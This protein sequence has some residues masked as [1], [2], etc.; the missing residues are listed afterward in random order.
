MNRQ[1]AREYI[2]Q[3][4]AEFFERD[5]SGSGFICPICG[6]GS[7]AKGTGITTKDGTHFTCWAGCFTS[8]DI[9]QIIGMQYGLAGFN[10]QLEKAA[11]ELGITIDRFGYNVADDF[12]DESQRAHTN[13]YTHTHTHKQPE[14]AEPEE[15]YTEFF[16]QAH[17]NLDKTNYH[18]GLPRDVLDRFGVG[19]VE[20]WKV[21]EKEYLKK[22]TTKDGR[23]R[24]HETWAAL[25]VSPRLI[26][27]TSPNSYLA[28]DTRPN[29]T[30]AEY[31]YRAPKVGK[32][33]ILN[34]D[35]IQ[36]ATSPIFIVEGEIDTL[37][38]IA[39]GGAAVGLGS[40]SMRGRLQRE[41]AKNRPQQ[42]L[43]IALDNDAAGERA[44]E[45]LEAFC[46]EQGISYY[47]AKDLYGSSKD[48]NEAWN[49]HREDFMKAVQDAE[50]AARSAATAAQEEAEA[51]KAAKLIADMEEIQGES[52]ANNID[53]LHD[54][55]RSRSSFIP[56]G[57]SGLDD[58]LDGGL[59]A[60]LYFIGAVS[61]LGKTSFML[62]M[63]DQI[64]Q[65]GQDV[66][67]FSLEMARAEL[68]AKSISRLTYLID[69]EENGTTAHAR[70]TRGILTGSLYSNY[71]EETIKV[72]AEAT[73]DYTEYAGHIYI[74]EG[75]GDLGIAKIKKRVKKHIDLMKTTPVVMIDY[76]QIIA[77]ADMR[78]TDKQNTDKAVSDLKRIS[79]DHNVPIIGISSFNRDNYTEPV[80]LTSFKESGAI[81]YSSDVLIGMQY[82][83]MDYKKTEKDGKTV[84]ESEKD[85]SS[86]VRSLLDDVAKKGAAGEALPIQV[87][88]LKSRNGRKGD[89]KLSF[90]PMF[91][92]YLDQPRQPKPTTAADD[93]TKAAL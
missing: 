91:N 83:G 53:K 75:V 66:I 44:A 48:A 67:I 82:E 29:L 70:T 24:T 89:V 12:A 63:A 7:G 25:P 59:F 22:E 36:T 5:R 23:P 50:T 28:R 62:Q 61:S 80:N 11:A 13:T 16:T 35:A 30:Q 4:S 79:R 74:V 68:M 51:E 38:I 58:I 26:I 93:W 37:S 47:R 2:L 14:T 33:H 45:A 42:P 73:K 39:A 64:A 57:F 52:G 54:Y 18:R 32:L 3:R 41:L 49:N 60:G 72:I 90:V 43:I 71:S 9:F 40:T 19:F 20:N 65:R 69:T 81:E 17:K 15:D 92:C 34:L 10:E 21:P 8:A 86:R 88:V 77:P 84:W 31:D 1:S 56:T 46:V 87:K 78:A 85:R 27:P 76:L 6:S 55:I